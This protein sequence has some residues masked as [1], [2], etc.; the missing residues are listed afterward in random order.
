M[1]PGHDRRRRAAAWALA[2]WLPLLAVPTATAPGRRRR[3]APPGRATRGRRRTSTASARPGGPRQRLVHAARRGADG[4][5]LPG[6]Q[7]AEL[8]RPRV[9]GHG[10]DDVPR[11]RDGAR[12]PRLGGPVR[13]P[14]RSPSARRRRPP[15]G[16]SSRRGSPIPRRATVL[17]DVRFESL[18][19]RPLQLYVSPTRRPGDDG[20]D[21]R[22]RAPRTA[23]LAWDDDAASAVIAEPP[24]APRDQRLR[25]LG[26][27]SVARPR[28]RHGA[29]T[30]ATAARGGQRRPGGAHA[31]HRPRRTAADDARDRLRRPTRRRPRGAAQRRWPPGSRTRPRA[32]RRRLGALPRLA[33]RPAGERRA[34]TGSCERL[35]DQSLMVLDA[36]ED[37]RY[38]GGSIASP[39]DAV[40]LGDAEL[41]ENEYLGPV[42]P[43]LAARLL[44]RRHRPAGGRR[45][46]ATDRLIDYLWRVQKPDGSWSQNTRVDGDAALDGLQLDE[47]ALPIVL[48][49]WLGR[50][51][52]ADW[53]HVR[54]RPTSSWPR[55]AH[56][57]GALGEPGRLLAEHDRHGDRR[58]WCAPPTSRART[59][60][61]PARRSYEASPTNGRRASRRGRRRPT[62]RYSAD[63]V[64]PAPDQGRRTRRRH[65]PT[66]SATTSP[67][68]RSTSAR[69]RPEL[70]RPGAV[71]RQA[72]RR[73]DGQQLARGRRPSSSRPT[74]RTAP[75]WHRFTFDGYGETRDGRHWDIFPTAAGQTLGRAVAAARRRA[76]RVRAAR[77]AASA[78]PHL[79]DDRGRR[80][81][82]A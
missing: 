14:G 49:W 35:Y 29:S 44:P 58:A 2:A 50:T 41:E 45:R 6:P 80:P 15:A 32:L 68:T 59:A 67:R 3:P 23:L 37:K 28:G 22:G 40:G 1:S 25:R 61:P 12:R 19:G 17:A 60:T 66:T 46:A 8:P 57:A 31:A 63:A 48:A 65:A 16:A 30:A 9:R 78:Q 38:R 5:L 55:A 81:T 82:T 42:P 77:R 79:R 10:R 47:V 24:P 75:I 27:R 54:G 34:A 73:P 21:D 20:N 43:G 52:A 4:D 53:E 76:R 56:A 39:D 69:R 64:L 71:R 26:E 70:P 33:E 7:H 62:A 51:S 36:S 11:P 72:A 13:R 18:T 74:R